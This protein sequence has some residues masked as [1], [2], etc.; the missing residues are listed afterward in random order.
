MPTC[1]PPSALGCLS[2]AGGSYSWMGCYQ[3]TPLVGAVQLTG[4]FGSATQCIAGC[5][6]AGAGYV[7][8]SIAGGSCYCGDSSST[9]TSTPSSPSTCNLLCSGDNTLC[10]GYDGSSIYSEVYQ[11]IAGGSSACPAIATS[12]SSSTL[13][14]STTTSSSATAPTGTMNGQFESGGLAPWTTNFL[15][16]VA[17]IKAPVPGFP[18]VTPFA[19]SSYVLQASLVGGETFS[20]QQTV[21]VCSLVNYAPK[22]SYQL[23]VDPSAGK[24]GPLTCTYQFCELISGTC[25]RVATMR[26]GKW[27]SNTPQWFT[28]A[29]QTTAIVQVNFRCPIPAVVYL[30]QLMM[31]PFQHG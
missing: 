29:T 9:P 14:T 24:K 21:P 1:A 18:S 15:N 6:N 13:S 26:A 16:E 12:T 31:N 30:G 4:S 8:A 2:L 25:G 17:I 27:G 22:I 5:S 11:Y 23:A 20:V 7:Y 19:P 28:K 10:G 3:S